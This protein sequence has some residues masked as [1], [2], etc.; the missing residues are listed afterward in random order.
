MGQRKYP[1]LK[2]A[3]VISI[4]RA[5]EFTQKGQEGSHAQ[6][7]GESHGQRRVVTVDTA[8]SEFDDF[9]IRSMIRQS[10]LTRVEFYLLDEE[11][12]PQG[13]SPSDSQDEII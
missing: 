6:Y 4:L 11:N 12:R 13:R 9:L 3:E 2:L 7:E 8:E 5:N 1:P 10:G